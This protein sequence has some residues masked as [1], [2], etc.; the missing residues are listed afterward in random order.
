MIRICAILLTLCLVGFVVAALVMTY[1]N[2]VAAF[3]ARR[4]LKMQERYVKIIENIVL[5]KR[6]SRQPGDT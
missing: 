2:Y 4:K 3:K 1:N 6:G 5:E